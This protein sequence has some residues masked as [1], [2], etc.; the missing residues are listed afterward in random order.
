MSVVLFSP[1]LSFLHSFVLS[2]STPILSTRHDST[3]RRDGDEFWAN[4]IPAGIS[5]TPCLVWQLLGGRDNYLCAFGI[6]QKTTA[7]DEDVV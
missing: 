6:R 3:Q 5:A 4:G 1:A 2:S 7:R